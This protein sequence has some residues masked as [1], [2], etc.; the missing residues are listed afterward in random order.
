M[1]NEGDGA[2]TPKVIGLGAFVKT[3][4]V[5]EDCFSLSDLFKY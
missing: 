1:L 2:P 3:E 5:V 4:L